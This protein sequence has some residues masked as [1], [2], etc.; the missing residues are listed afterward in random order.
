MAD[1][2]ISIKKLARALKVSVAALEGLVKA[3]VP[4]RSQVDPDCLLYEEGFVVIA[5]AHIMREQKIREKEALALMKEHGIHYRNREDI[6][7]IDDDGIFV[8]KLRM[9]ALRS[10]A[11]GVMDAS[12][13][14]PPPP[15]A[16]PAKQGEGDPKKEG[17]AD[18]S[19]QTE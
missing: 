9:K 13:Y 2:L 6:I 11:E 4:K 18:E 19:I 15:P 12:R 1:K 5:C 17:G 16:E 10:L 7:R 14:E 3:C 8:T